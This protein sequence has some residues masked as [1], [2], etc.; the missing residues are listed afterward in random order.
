MIT[1]HAA[2]QFVFDK[3]PYDPDRGFPSITLLAKSPIFLIVHPSVPANNVQEFIA[4]AKA[5][6]DKLSYATTG[7]G[8]SFHLATE[9]SRSTPESRWSTCPT[10]AWGRLPDD[11]LSGN[12]QVALD[13]RRSRRCGTARRRWVVGETRFAGAPIFPP[14]PNR[15]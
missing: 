2:N 6:P 14:S 9:H 4:C 3:P 1:S 12:V 8:S 5:N 15:G 11:L 7:H 13:V 10:K